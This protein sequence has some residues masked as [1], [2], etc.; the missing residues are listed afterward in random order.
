MS[1]YGKSH[2]PETLHEAPSS[3]PQYPGPRE[4]SNEELEGLFGV[5]ARDL[6]T[7]LEAVKARVRSWQSQ[8]DAY[9]LP[10]QFSP[11][12]DQHFN[13][14]TR[15]SHPSLNRSLA[16]LAYEQWLAQPHPIFVYGTLKRGEYNHNHIHGASTL[17]PA[18]LSGYR[19]Y[20]L[21]FGYPTITPAHSPEAPVRGDLIQP[22]RDSEDAGR[23]ESRSLLL[24]TDRLEGF[25][26]D[27]PH[28]SFYIRT[29]VQVAL[30]EENGEP[31]EPCT[32]W[33]YQA[34]ETIMEYL[35][36]ERIIY[37]GCWTGGGVR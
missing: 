18:L 10:E 29:L 12:N 25:D 35:T 16:K 19:L 37:T 27:H 32:A 13:A 15:Q 8:P 6:G 2:P 30:L 11:R 5:A 34:G 28:S 9:S 20:H 4:L 36:T 33:V 26:H 17:S 23:E 31:G 7:T 21:P 1:P 22:A 14:D 3:R 24:S